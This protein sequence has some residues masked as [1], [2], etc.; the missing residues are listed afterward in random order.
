MIETPALLQLI[1]DVKEKIIFDL[2]CGDAQF[3]TELLQKGCASYIKIQNKNNFLLGS[4]F[5]F[6]FTE[7]SHYF[8]YFYS[9]YVIL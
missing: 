8:L 4:C 7:M 5:Y 6:E 1:C 3:R 2:E 9:L